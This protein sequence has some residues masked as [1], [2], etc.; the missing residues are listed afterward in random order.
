MSEEHLLAEGADEHE[1]QQQVPDDDWT[2]P[3]SSDQAPGEEVV[4]LND[5]YVGGGP[6]PEQEPH[7][8]DDQHRTGG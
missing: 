3:E 6:P 8:D 1:A 2:A 7:L 4:H 5:A